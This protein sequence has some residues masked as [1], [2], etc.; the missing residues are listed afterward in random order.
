MDEIGMPLYTETVVATGAKLIP[1]IARSGYTAAMMRPLIESDLAAYTG[2]TPAEVLIDL[3]ANDMGYYHAS[4]SEA[5]WKAD[6][7]Y[8]MDAMHTWAPLAKVRVAKP[9]I[10]GCEAL[11]PGCN[12]VAAWVD[13]LVAARSGWAFVSMDERDWLPANS[14]DGIHPR[15]PSGYQEM[16]R[17]LKAGMGY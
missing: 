13:D 5:Q 7:G 17:R 8:I 9:W 12:E 15:Y 1:A 16:A 6:M 3:G 4:L 11:T 2:P 14:D 10:N